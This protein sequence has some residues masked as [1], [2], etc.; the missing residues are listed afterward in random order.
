MIGISLRTLQRK[1]KGSQ[2][3]S[4]VESDRLYRLARIYATVTR[5]LQDDEMAKDWMNRPHADLVAGFLLKR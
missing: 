3:L 5:I 4:M 2:R 1:R